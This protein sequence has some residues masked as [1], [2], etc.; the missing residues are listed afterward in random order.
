MADLQTIIDGSI[1]TRWDNDLAKEE[2]MRLMDQIRAL[3]E[4]H[5]K[6]IEPIQNQAAK[7]YANYTSPIYVITTKETK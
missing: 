5:R 4:I 1:G 3:H 2:Y 7:L 6:A